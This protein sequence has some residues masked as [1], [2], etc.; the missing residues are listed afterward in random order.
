MEE[1]QQLAEARHNLEE[2]E[3]LILERLQLE[4]EERAALL[5][6]RKQEERKRG[7]R[8]YQ[9]TCKNTIAV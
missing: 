1:A 4:E 5:Q 9:C 6:S 2:R 8:Y 7:G 3:L